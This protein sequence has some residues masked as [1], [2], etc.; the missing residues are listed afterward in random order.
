MIRNRLLS[1]IAIICLILL[2]NCSLMLSFSSGKVVAG[3]FDEYWEKEAPSLGWEEK[4]PGR[5]V[6]NVFLKT[7]NL[8][9]KIGVFVG[10]II[11]AYL[12]FWLI[13]TAIIG[14]NKSPAKT[15]TQCFLY[16]MLSFYIAAFLCFSEY[17]LIQKYDESV[18]Y[19]SQLNWSIILIGLAVWTVS[20]FIMT[21]VLRGK[22]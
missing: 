16:Y 11:V 18:S 1:R 13:F 14:K 15:F 12:L 8:L 19:L 9:M 4:V 21:F 3:R 17:A 2:I 22:S 20:S 7:D 10:W 6:Y 5:G